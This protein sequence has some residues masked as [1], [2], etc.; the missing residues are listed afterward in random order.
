MDNWWEVVPERTPQEII[1]DNEIK[2]VH[3]HAK[4]GGISKRE[5][6]N[7]G[8]LKCAFGYHQG[9]TARHI[10]HDHGLIKEMY[11]DGYQLTTKGREYL[12]AV[13]NIEKRN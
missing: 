3:A 13:W 5:V 11:D 6:V 12:L 8:V 9:H 10:L 2:D 4:F 7:R 1:P